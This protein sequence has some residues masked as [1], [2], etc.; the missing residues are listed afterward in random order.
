MLL[1]GAEALSAGMAGVAPG[2]GVVAVPPEPGDAGV[3]GVAG[4]AWANTPTANSPANKAARNLFMSFFPGLREKPDANVA[5]PALNAK[6][7]R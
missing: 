5:G 1:L 7:F 6:A 4:V 3:A 2:D